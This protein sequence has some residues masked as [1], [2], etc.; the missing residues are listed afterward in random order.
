MF[1]PIYVTLKSPVEGN[2]RKFSEIISVERPSA[3]WNSTKNKTNFKNIDFCHLKFGSYFKTW[4]PKLNSSFVMKINWVVAKMRGTRVWNHGIQKCDSSLS[5]NIFIRC[6]FYWSSIK[7]FV[8]VFVNHKVNP[9]SVLKKKS[10]VAVWVSEPKGK[11]TDQVC[12]LRFKLRNYKLVSTKF[13]DNF[14]EVE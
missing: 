14:L 8:S 5:Y 11:I 3:S 9:K 6:E 2:L 13:V 7:L 1:P 4:I 12:N 10:I